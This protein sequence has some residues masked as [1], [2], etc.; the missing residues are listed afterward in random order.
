M[1]NDDITAHARA[2]I[3][4]NLYLVLGTADTPS[5]RRG[6]CPAATSTAH[7]RSIHGRRGRTPR[8]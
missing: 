3:D 7:W 6:S 5:V 4:A 8:G 1:T 2:I